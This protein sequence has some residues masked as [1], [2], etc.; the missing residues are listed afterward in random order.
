[1][2]AIR[3]R[4][5]VVGAGIA[6]LSAA[7][8][9]VEAGW[10]VSVHEASDRFGGK[11]RSSLVGDR[12][13][14]AGPDTFLARAAPGLQLCK[15][16]GIAGELTSPIAP[17]G[18]Y[19]AHNDRLHPL[20]PGSILGVPTDLDALARSELI[21]AA[22][23]ERA[24][25]DLTAPDSR[26]DLPTTDGDVSV[27]AL[28]RARLGD[29]VTDLLIDPLLGGINASDIDRL[30]LEAGAPLLA[31]AAADQDSLIAGLR[32]L[33]PSTGPALG[34]AGAQPVFYG[35][36]GGIERLIDALV[37]AIDDRA[38][39]LVNSPVSN[40]VDLLDSVDA[41]VIAAPAWAAAE[42]VRPLSARAAEELDAFE[43]ATVSQVTVEVPLGAVETEL[44]ASGILFPR[45]GGTIM[46]ASTWFSSKWAHYQ[47]PSS[48]LIRLSSGRFGD[49]RA[50]DL[51][52][53]ELVEHLLAEL[54][55]VIPMTAKP[56]AVRVQR[57]PKAFPQYTP[58][59]LARV[60]R[61]MAE[62]RRSAPSVHLVGATYGG[63]GIPACIDGG[64]D[65]ARSIMASHP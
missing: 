3:A 60:D 12:L 59:H 32:A 41:A 50:L 19:L 27:G 34:S 46:T 20:P 45:V 51:G 23:A 35:F 58:G 4:A 11:I 63:I 49:D 47:R 39:L 55:E 44:D 31:R 61:I 14:D 43:H 62:L 7:F 17:V 25:L 64:R 26:A 22:G 13:V 36:P 24:A 9:L 40:I 28:C 6:G 10:D 21:S 18:A 38:T 42:L 5:L 29:E 65:A 1:M 33:R 56:T 37:N 2:S 30:S 54:H 15:D 53:D 8:D 48:V 16:L 52:D 57:W